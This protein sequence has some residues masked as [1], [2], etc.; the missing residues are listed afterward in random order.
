VTRPVQGGSNG[1]WGDELNEWLDVSHNDD[2]T[3][4]GDDDLVIKIGGTT[5]ATF[6][7]NGDVMIGPNVGL[8]R[9]SGH[10]DNAEIPIDFWWDSLHRRLHVRTLLVSETGDT[11]ELGLRRAGG[12]YPDGPVDVITA[13]TALGLIH[14]TGTE[15][16]SKTLQ[17][18]SAQIYARAAE[19]ITSTAAGGALYLATTPNGTVA[20]TI[21]RIKIAQDGAVIVLGG[22]LSESQGDALA[23][24]GDL[25]LSGKVYA[26]GDVIARSALSGGSSTTQVSIGA[27]GP[28]SEAGIAFDSTPQA[29]LYLKSNSY[30]RTDGD[31]EARQLKT[32][33]GGGLTLVDG[34]DITIGSSTGSKI[35]QA[36]SKIGF[37]GVTPITRALL[38]TGAGHTV[39]DVI[40][41]LQN[42]GLVKQS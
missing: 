4:G 23:G 5:I 1:S 3:L 28:S 15:S 7:S 26:I 2:G 13:N 36:G 25:A 6:G 27:F 34:N 21:D 19:D 30:L 11:P 38:A 16:T 33:S 8:D 39:D 14:W 18:R 37:Y 20:G 24:R 42:L 41:A 40:T 22:S 10:S 32:I 12:T 17:H 35:G 29:R 9:T 31:F